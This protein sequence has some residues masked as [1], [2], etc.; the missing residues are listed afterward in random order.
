MTLGNLKTLSRSYVK[1]AKKNVISDAVLETILGEGAIDVARRTKCLSANEKFNVMEDQRDYDLSSELT[2]YLLP[3]KSGLYWYNGSNWLRRYPRTRKWIDKH[4]QNWR[5]SSSGDPYYYF[6][7]ND[8]LTVEPPPD[9]SLDEGF[10]FYFFQK[11][12]TMS[13]EDFHIFG[14][15]SEISR[16]SILSESVLL[17]WKIR[18]FKILGKPE[19]IIVMAINEY[20]AEIAE[21]VKLLSERP[22]LGSSKYAKYQGRKVR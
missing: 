17:Y 7:E 3:A 20:K 16:L 19:N 1:A 14:G 8:V 6:I 15:A 5:D 12:P 2:R 22:D 4:K 9:T 18:A 13:T 11:P 10:H 21:K